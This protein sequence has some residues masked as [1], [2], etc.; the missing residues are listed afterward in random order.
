MLLVAGPAARGSLPDHRASPVRPE[1]TQ[2]L[3]ARGTWMIVRFSRGQLPLSQ[4][5]RAP[6]GPTGRLSKPVLEM[7]IKFCH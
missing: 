1:A 5:E 7:S 6:W 2:V 4:P 3:L